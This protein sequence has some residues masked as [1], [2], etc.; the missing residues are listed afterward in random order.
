M[1]AAGR[2]VPSRQKAEAG[3]EGWRRS[4]RLCAA[5]QLRIKAKHCFNRCVGRQSIISLATNPVVVIPICP[6]SSSASLWLSLFLTIVFG[7]PNLGSRKSVDNFVYWPLVIAAFKFST[8]FLESSVGT[9]TGIFWF[10]FSERVKLLLWEHVT[11]TEKKAEKMAMLGNIC[12]N[13]ELCPDPAR[14][15]LSSLNWNSHSE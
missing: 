12:V 7:E 4:F 5:C 3:T 10:G 9:S 2:E 15:V 6:W 8:V 11:D 13:L 14:H 1:W